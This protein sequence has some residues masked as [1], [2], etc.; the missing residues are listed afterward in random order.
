MSQ[1][2]FLQKLTENPPGAVGSLL[3]STLEDLFGT[4]AADLFTLFLATAPPT[5]GKHP[6]GLLTGCR[7]FN[8]YRTGWRSGRPFLGFV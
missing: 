3:F 8:I 7:T 2:G 5:K 1:S 6:A 4:F